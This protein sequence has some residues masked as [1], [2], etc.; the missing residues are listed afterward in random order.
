MRKNFNNKCSI[1][2]RLPVLINFML[3][4]ECTVTGDGML[5]LQNCFN[6]VIKF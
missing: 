5:A 3:L 6:E 2:A 1:N 4:S